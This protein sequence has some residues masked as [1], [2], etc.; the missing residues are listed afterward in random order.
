M[1]GGAGA[2]AAATKAGWR[3]GVCDSVAS[4]G[5]PRLSLR[6][7]KALGNDSLCATGRR[8]VIRFTSD[9]PARRPACKR[10]RPTAPMAPPALEPV[11]PPERPSAPCLLLARPTPPALP[12]SSAQP[13]SLVERLVLLPRVAEVEGRPACSRALR[14]RSNL[15]VS[16]SRVASSIARA[17]LSPPLPP[18]FVTSIDTALR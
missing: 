12:S 18:R 15:P 3:L 17:A 7:E 1:A 6:G 14:A 9:V 11:L 5:E 16:A 8:P 4:V 2:A 13:I 10:L